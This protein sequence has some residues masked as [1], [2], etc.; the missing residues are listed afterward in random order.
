MRKFYAYIIFL[1]LTSFAL[2]AQNHTMGVIQA[3][4]GMADGY[5]LFAPTNTKETYLIDNCGRLV[6]AWTSSTYFPGSAVYLL[7][8]GSLLRTGRILNNNFVMGGLGGRLEQYTWEDSLTW[9]WNYSSSTHT[10]HHDVEPLPNGNLLVLG[11]ET[12]NALDMNFA[13]RNPALMNDN[14][15]WSE[16]IF[17]IQPI[18]SDSAAVVWEWHA[19]DHLVQDFD[20]T[21]SNYGIVADH[22]ELIDINYYSIPATKDWLHANSV[23]YDVARDQVMI[24]LAHVDEFWILDHSTS[25]VEAATHTGGNRGKGGDLLYRW[26]NPRAYERG[27]SADQKLFFMHDAHWIPPGRPDSGKVLI[28]NNGQGRRYSTVEIMEL[29]ESSLGEYALSQGQAYGPVASEWIYASDS[30]LDFFSKIMSGAQQQAN[31]NILMCN[32][33]YG[34]A[35]EVNKSFDTLWHYVNP[36]TSSGATNQGD[37]G[38]VGANA[39]FRIERY[40]PSFVGFVGKD[41]TPGDPLEGMFDIANCLSVL[42]G[43]NEELKSLPIAIYPNPSSKI[44]NI[45]SKNAAPQTV[46]IWNAFGQLVFEGALHGKLQIDVQTWIGGVYFMKINNES[47]R[48]IIVIQ[49]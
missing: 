49:H 3:T 29:P 48:K 37:T 12:K 46:K 26:G 32:G 33:A 42:T 28:F 43:A 39:T 15:M 5:S 23:D 13:G 41:L 38:P 44:V 19:W 36:M 24:T 17:E 8:D 18:G 7:E 10:L 14:L 16:F 47:T 2:P 21:K 45:F 40:S 31:G 9:S 35:L 1:L 22:P 30:L 25:T 27:D 6:N 4:S 11:V 34:Y 20:S